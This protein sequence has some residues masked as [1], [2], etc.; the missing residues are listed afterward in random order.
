MRTL[1][2]AFFACSFCLLAADAPKLRL[3]ADIRPTRY[4]ADLTAVPGTA[5]FSGVLDIDIALAKP[6][7]LVWLN[8]TDLS[9]E[10]ATVN[11]Q[12]AAV[13][14]AGGDFIALRPPAARPARSAPPPPAPRARRKST[15][16]PG[17]NP[18][19]PGARNFSRA[20]GEPRRAGGAR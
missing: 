13:E 12:P 16:A 2:L 15:A 6:A 8:A 4:A 20:G 7:S 17:T 10:Q 14:S 3:G 9:I 1:A 11:S 18:A 19:P 5:T